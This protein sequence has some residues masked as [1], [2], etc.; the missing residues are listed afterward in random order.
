MERKEII[1]KLEQLCEAR[2]ICYATSDRS[3]QE[4]QIGDD[5][6]PVFYQHLQAIGSVDRIAVLLYRLW[7]RCIVPV[8][9]SACWHGSCS[10]GT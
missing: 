10:T 9:R 3:G 1:S 7:A 2:V 4:T 6:G 5:A 8:N